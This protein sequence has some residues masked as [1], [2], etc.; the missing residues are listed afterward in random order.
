MKALE[1][2]QLLLSD[3]VY[4]RLDVVNIHWDDRDEVDFSE[5]GYWQVDTADGDQH[6]VFPDE[7]DE[8]TLEWLREIAL[9]T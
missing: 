3:K 4:S 5:A 8:Q 1:Y 2:D 7:V 9:P 6:I